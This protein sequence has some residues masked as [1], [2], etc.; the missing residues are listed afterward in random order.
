MPHAEICSCGCGKVPR[1][2]D[3]VDGHKPDFLAKTEY[4]R[5]IKLAEKH[6]VPSPNPTILRDAAV[7]TEISYVVMLREMRRFLRD[8]R[9]SFELPTLTCHPLLVKRHIH[10]AFVEAIQTIDELLDW[11][12]GQ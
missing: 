1:N 8:C 6:G 11:P 5:V 3:W 10:R 12:D 2:G 4:N 7:A 9:D